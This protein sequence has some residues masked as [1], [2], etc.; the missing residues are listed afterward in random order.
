M[1]PCPPVSEEWG[2]EGLTLLPRSPT[3]PPI[4][5]FHDPTTN[6]RR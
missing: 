4:D 1:L 3:H 5:I 2:E 6:R